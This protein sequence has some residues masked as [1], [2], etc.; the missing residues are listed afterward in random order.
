[1]RRP[2]TARGTTFP[3]LADLHLRLLI[4]LLHHD[5]PAVHNSIWLAALDS[6][7]LRDGKLKY[8]HLPEPDGIFV[9]SGKEGAHCVWD[10]RSSSNIFV[11]DV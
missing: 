5:I 2:S 1:M 11:F 4:R 6:D 7:D 3:N 10:R 9:V 8:L